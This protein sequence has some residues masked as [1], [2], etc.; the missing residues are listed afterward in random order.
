MLALP[1]GVGWYQMFVVIAG[2]QLLALAFPNVPLLGIG[3]PLGFHASLAAA[4]TLVV[5]SVVG[6]FG[7]RTRQGRSDQSVDMKMMAVY[8]FIGERQSNPS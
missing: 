4:G 5:F 2:M 7:G 8:A 1:V 3:L 6:W